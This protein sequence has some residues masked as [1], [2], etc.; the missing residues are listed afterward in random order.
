M[1][2]A[3]ES[4][5]EYPVHF[6]ASVKPEDK[7][8]EATPLSATRLASVYWFDSEETKGRHQIR[9][10]FQDAFL[11]IRELRCTDGVW[12][13]DSRPCFLPPEY[14]IRPPLA[15][16]T[17]PSQWGDT[18]ARD[19][20][21][22]IRLYYI[23]IASS[24]SPASDLGIRVFWQDGRGHIWQN[25]C[26]EI[27]S[28]KKWEVKQ[29]TPDKDPALQ[30][31]YL[32]SAVGVGYTTTADAETIVAWQKPGNVLAGATF[33]GTTD[34]PTSIVFPR[35]YRVSPSGSITVAAW[36]QGRT[37]IYY[38][39]RDRESIQKLSISPVAI[40]GNDN[41]LESLTDDNGLRVKTA[42]VLYEGPFN[43]LT[44][45]IRL[46]VSPGQASL[47]SAAFSIQLNERLGNVFY[48]LPGQSKLGELDI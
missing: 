18:S 4:V 38:D 31:T 13:V 47:A 20:E 43:A 28:T 5:S 24:S 19:P 27:G 22:E 34:T 14:T 6:T 12:A 32:A 23:A 35:A 46:G 9:V 16:I 41:K 1:S 10:Y 44:G 25:I 26:Q 48:L 39:G 15:A 17:C 37:L 30:G 7:N 40:S 45:D 29:V 3:S 42:S 33:K 2:T 21:P 36:H 11:W 8:K